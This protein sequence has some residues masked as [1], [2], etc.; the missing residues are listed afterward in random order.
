MKTIVF[1]HGMFQNSKSWHKW[2]AYFVEKGYKCIA[3]AWPMHKGEPAALRQ[4]PPAGL[5]GLRLQTVIHE[6]ETVVRALPEPP[7]VIGHSVGGLI[8]Q[9]LVAKGLVD[10]GIPIASVAPNAMLAFD[11]RFIKNSA[12]ITNPVKGND[13]FYMDL[14]SFHDSFCNTMS[15]EETKAAYEE[16]ATHDS[17]NILRDCL[18]TAAQIN[19]DVPHAPMLFIGAEK[20]EII[21][22]TLAKRNAEAYTDEMSIS[23][24]R[25]FANRS[26]WICGQPGWEEA[27]GY[28][29]MWLQN[30]G[31]LQYHAPHLQLH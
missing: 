4:N 11:W 12:L 9:I 20:D 22:A 24:Y 25:E 27:A 2:I 19:L 18:G 26:H 6:M 30:H 21:P 10:I 28:I 14:Q 13:P 3:P 16:T 15:E 5:G 8:A 17:R 7:V 1:I 31:H 29:E 23:E